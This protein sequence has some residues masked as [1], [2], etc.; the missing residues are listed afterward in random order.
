MIEQERHKK[1]FEYYFS[2]GEKRNHRQVAKEYKMSLASVKLWSRSFD[3]KLRVSERDAEVAREIAAQVINDELSERRRNKQIVHMALVQLARAIADSKVRM[4]LSD[5]DKLIRLEAFL[6]EK[7][8]QELNP[9]YC[10][11]DRGDKTDEELKEE[12]ETRLDLLGYQ[13]ID[14][15]SERP[16]RVCDNNHNIEGFDGDDESS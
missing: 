8:K 16:P 4:T 6:N 13:L 9:L 5:L 10:G 3:W 7:P 11:T 15:N 2:L 12:F 14:E 1:A